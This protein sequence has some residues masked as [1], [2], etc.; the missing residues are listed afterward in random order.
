[1]AGLFIDGFDSFLSGDIANANPF[2]WRFNTSHAT[3]LPTGGKN[4][5]GAVRVDRDD[6]HDWRSR[7][8]STAGNT[9][10][11]AVWMK[12]GSVVPVGRIQCCGDD[13]DDTVRNVNFKLDSDGRLYVEAYNGGSLLA[14]EFANPG[15]LAGKADTWVHFEAEVK[16]HSSAGVVKVWLDGQSVINYSG[17]TIDAGSA[18]DWD[19]ISLLCAAGASQHCDYDDLVVW[20]SSG[21]GGLAVGGPIGGGTSYHQIETFAPTGAGNSTQWTPHS[22]AN[23]ANVATSNA[24][25]N[26]SHT[27]NDIDLFTH[28]APALPHSDIVAVA[29]R[30]FSE[31]DAAT[32]QL[33]AVVRHGGSNAESADMSVSAGNSRPKQAL[34]E[35]NPAASPWSVS[36]LASMEFGYKDQTT[37]SGDLYVDQCICEVLSLETFASES[38]S[39]SESASESESESA[40]EA[41][42]E[43]E[44]ESTPAPRVLRPWWRSRARVGRV[45]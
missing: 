27:A 26:F 33:R 23:W 20:D 9:I 36:E 1:M 31:I 7:F 17:S 15:Y 30:M 28:A 8:F 6:F 45:R 22:A 10:H 29:V 5:G 37:N 24:A 39:E 19:G 12:L 25:W 40:S 4:G 11:W 42:S 32:Y 3:G 2:H 41:V 13:W 21:S 43:S 14:T 38:E 16:L 18:S 35:N 34:F 44:S